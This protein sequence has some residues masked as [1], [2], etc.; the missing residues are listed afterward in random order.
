VTDPWRSTLLHVGGSLTLIAVVA[1]VLWARGL[2]IRE[3]LALWWPSAR[4]IAAWVAVF[5]VLVVVEEMMGRLLGL[6]APEPWGQRYTGAVLLVRLIG[7][8]ILAAV[9]E[10]LVFRGALFGRILRTRLGENGA[11]V[12]PAVLFALMHVQYSLLEMS[13][14]VVDGLFFGLARARSRSLYLPMLLHALGNTLAA[15]QRLVA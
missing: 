9:A 10:E 6:P 13:F 4:T 15:T 5:A 2:P 12:I 14:I 11:V 8:I 3:F 7:L 1:L